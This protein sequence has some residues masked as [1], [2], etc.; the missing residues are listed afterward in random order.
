[1][2]I[3]PTGY[4]EIYLSDEGIEKLGM[5]KITLAENCKME[6]DKFHLYIH[7]FGSRLPQFTIKKKY[8]ALAYYKPRD[9]YDDDKYYIVKYSKQNY[10]LDF[11]FLEENNET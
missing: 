2:Y 1:M 8:I 7:R 3:H 9:W 4:G 6:T 5:T 11:K 10:Y